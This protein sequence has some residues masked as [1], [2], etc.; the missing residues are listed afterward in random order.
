[1]EQIPYQISVMCFLVKYL[2]T[3]SRSQCFCKKSFKKLIENL[4]SC[5]IVYLNLNIYVIW[6]L[7]FIAQCISYKCCREI[8]YFFFF[9]LKKKKRERGEWEKKGK[10]SNV[11][12]VHKCRYLE[13][14]VLAGNVRREKFKK[15]VLKRLVVVD[16]IHPN[17]QT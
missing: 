9:Y 6:M 8:L 1:M 2:T 13:I 12:Y 16:K 4:F 15:F 11:S 7:T 5:K 17:A 14:W 10:E 3:E